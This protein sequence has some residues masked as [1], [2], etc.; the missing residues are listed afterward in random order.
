MIDCFILMS[1]NKLIIIYDQVNNITC[2]YFK[3]ALWNQVGFVI[4]G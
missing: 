2:N 1:W 3:I 4:I